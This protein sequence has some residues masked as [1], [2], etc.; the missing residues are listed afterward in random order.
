MYRLF[1]DDVR[2]PQDVDHLDRDEDWVI[3]RNYDE[4]VAII[5]ESGLPY[6]MS[7]DHDLG[8][9]KTGY[10]CLK[11]MIYEKEYD[12]RKVVIN[13]HSGNPVGKLDMFTLVKNW[14][15]HLDSCG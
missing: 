2:F 7:L 1:L 4:F 6:E 14:R 15:N 13:Y 10:D 11:W 9:A 12:L 8:E 3:A 5:E